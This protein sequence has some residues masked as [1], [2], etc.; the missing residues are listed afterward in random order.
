MPL[1]D[2][3]KA[4]ERIDGD[5]QKSIGKGYDQAKEVEDRFISED[6]FEIFDKQKRKIA[7]F[8][9]LILTKYSL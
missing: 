5:F 8:D 7:T 6:S 4:Y 9:P 3:E 2:E 1:R